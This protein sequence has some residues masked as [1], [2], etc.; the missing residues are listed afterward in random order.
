M[1]SQSMLKSTSEIF[2]LYGGNSPEREISLQSGAA[3][4]RSLGEAGYNVS[5]VDT[6]TT[7]LQA[8]DWKEN[9]VAIIMLH[10]TY[11]EDG[12]VQA[13][14]ES[15][16]VIYS[17]SD[18]RSSQRAFHKAIAKKTF[19]DHQLP[20][21]DWRLLSSNA[22]RNE[23][24]TAA[25]QI[26]APV[27]IKPEA[28][29]SSLGVTILENLSEVWSAFEAARELDEQVL[30]ERAILGEEW[31]VPVLDQIALPA[32]RIRSQRQFFD[33]S[34]KYLDNETE[35]HVLG[36][37]DSP[38]ARAVTDVSLN[39]CLHL[40]TSGV[41]RVDLMVDAQG[42][43]WLLEVN[44][45]PGMTEHSLVPKAAAHLGWSMSDLCEQILFS[46]FANRQER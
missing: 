6:A 12:E 21:P 7:S 45:I 43:P 33:Y 1:R 31:T 34:A 2:V 3:F 9:S 46:A 44:T 17:G 37:D 39:A 24:L 23:V 25:Q 35:Y 13:E 32:I 36:P 11:G 14:L 15:L 5:L 22:S 40:Q 41:C 19:E 8:V 16:G 18:V 30:I 20:T 27:V 4:G 10:G 38:I 29:G 26:G 42:I 28:Q